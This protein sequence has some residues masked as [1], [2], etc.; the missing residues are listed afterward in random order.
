MKSE[1]EYFAFIVNKDGIQ[2]SPKKVEAMLKVP[3]PEN[4]KELQSWLGL[5]NYYRKFIPDMSTVLQPLN[6][7]LT[8]KSKWNWNENCKKSFLKI[9]KLLSSTK[10]LAHYDPNVNVELAVDASPYGLGCV[11]SH[12]YENGEERPI[13]YASRTLTS[14]ERN[15][16]QIEREAL[17]IIFG[18]TRFHQ[19]LYGRKFTLITDNKPLSLL[20]GPKTGIPMLVASRIQ[21]WAIQLSG[22]QY[23]V[24]CKSSSEN[25]NAD[26]LSRLP[27]KETL[28]E[29]PFNIFW[30][31]VEI[32]NVQALN[33]LPVSANKI[34]RETEKDSTLVKVK[35]ATLYGWPKYTDISNEL[36]PYFRVKDEL[37]M[38]EGCLLRGI[39]VI[40]PERYRAD[41]LNE[42]HVNH[43]GIVRMKGLA[44]MHVWWPNLDTDIEITVRNCTA[45][46]NT[47][48]A[49]PAA[50]AN[51][52]IWPSKPWQRVHI[53]FCGPFLNEMFLIVVDA[54]SKWI[55]VIR[56]SSTTSEKTINALR[57]LFSSHGIP[58]EIVS[59]NGP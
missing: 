41:V 6:E 13:A 43:P 25:A 57:C 17:A 26:G 21:R 30:E 49:P 28:C 27:L 36:K 29:S 33:E 37:S 10:V 20:L 51:P 50:T 38:E 46:Q 14:A 45:C 22:Y 39:R 4:V 42:L 11:I 35:H 24:K 19:Y 2:P 1:V 44:R 31:E 47:Q 59:D 34:K 18:V 12:K 15:Y 9:S 3:E 56:M 54:H 52:W 32:R 40:I 7:L 48:S 58:T 23:D 55:D 16:S 53:D 5:V 8:K